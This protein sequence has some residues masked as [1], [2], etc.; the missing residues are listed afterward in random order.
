MNDQSACVRACVRH[1][2]S[3]C[4]TP[5]L[6]LLVETT[7]SGSVEHVCG[8]SHTCVSVRI[9]LFTWYSLMDTKGHLK[10]PQNL[11][12]PFLLFERYESEQV[13]TV[14]KQDIHPSARTHWTTETH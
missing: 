7:S 13:P 9:S 4:H 3:V 12:V 11:L 8:T 1:T 5:E 6:H 10:S 14:K 2:E